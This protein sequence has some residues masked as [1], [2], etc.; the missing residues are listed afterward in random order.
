MAGEVR[1]IAMG[2]GKIKFGT[3]GDGVPGT[4]LKEFPL[5]FKGSVA[6]NFADPKEVKIET[7]GSDE[8][9]YVEFVKDTT[10]YIEFSIPT[11]SNEV[12]K[13][14]AGGE[15]ET[16]GGKNIWNKPLNVPSIS[17]T[18]QCETLPKDGKK[19]VYTIVNGKV[20]SKISQAPGSE[21]AELLLVRV[22][23]QAAITIAG[24]KKTAFMREVVTVTEEG[25]A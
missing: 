19:V 25:A 5:P 14:L 23:V 2:V 16:T 21:Q 22:Y 9:L 11:P 24:V 12:I 6:F 17:K 1:P 13:D 20:S 10:D 15:I 18:F 4:D 7:E 3:V 8:P